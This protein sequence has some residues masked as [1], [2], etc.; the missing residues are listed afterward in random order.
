MMLSEKKRCHAMEGVHAYSPSPPTPMPQVC[1]WLPSTVGPAP[2]PPPRPHLELAPQVGHLVQP[3][4]LDAP[5]AAPL[6]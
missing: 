5:V 3:V 2:T 6:A 4:L 1:S